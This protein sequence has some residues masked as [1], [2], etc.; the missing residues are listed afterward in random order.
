M[1]M[2]A[3]STVTGVVVTCTKS[4]CVKNQDVIYQSSFNEGCNGCLRSCCCVL[5]EGGLAHV[6]YVLLC[7]QGVWR[8]GGSYVGTCVLRP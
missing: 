8:L 6:A 2:V 5:T 7:M 4:E 1:M 3:P